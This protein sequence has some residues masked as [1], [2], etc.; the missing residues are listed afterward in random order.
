MIK[1]KLQNSPWRSRF[2]NILLFSLII[3]FFSRNKS[4]SQIKS[5]QPPVDVGLASVDITPETP[6]LLTGFAARPR[7]ETDTILRKLSAKAIAI[8]SDNQNPTVMITIDLVGITDY[9]RNRVVAYLEKERGIGSDH[10]SIFASHTH[11][12]PEIGNLIN[13]IQYRDGGFDHPYLSQQEFSHLA[14]YA[15][16]LVQKLKD[17]AVAALND[18]KPALLS[19]NQGQAYFA[20]NRRTKPGEPAGPVDVALPM[21]KISNPDGSLR[22]MFINYA[23]H[24]TTVSVNQIS[25]DWIGEAHAFIEER[26]PGVTALIALGTAGDANPEPRG[27]VENMKDHGKEMADRVDILLQSQTFEPISHP[28]VAKMEW[29]DLPLDDIPSTSELYETANSNN[30]VISYQARRTL[31]KMMRGE[32]IPSSVRYPVQVWNFDNKMAMVNLGGEVV[33]DYSIMLKDK[34]GAEKIW[35]NGYANDIQGYTPS[36]RILKEGGYEAEHNMYWYNNAAPYKPEVQDIIMN[37]VD[38]IMPDSFKVERPE[39]NTPQTIRKSSDNRYY[40]SSWFA[41]IVDGKSQ[42]ENIA[43]MPEWK[44][45]GWFRTTDAATW[46]MEVAKSGKYDV[47]VEYSV[48]DASAG[49][50]YELAIGKSK[51]KGVTQKSGSWFTYRKDKIGTIN[52]KKGNQKASVKAVKIDKSGSSVFDLREITLV[53]KR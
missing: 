47:Y 21:L 41:D 18:R 25:G 14:E 19:W 32:K 37:T 31:D 43:Y 5:T 13:I 22:G 16:A 1:M 15:E 29:V 42:V 28:P 2:F 6:V 27:T 49:K 40:L 24:G 51:V 35:T 52:L 23:C 9:L 12:G 8:G 44:A 26:H 20:I 36:K 11:S 7:S 46:D 33:V 30:S 4:Y 3:L 34:Y 10:I 50:E 48:A 17:V 39:T 53:P 38:V 45:F